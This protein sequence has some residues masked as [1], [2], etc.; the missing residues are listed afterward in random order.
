MAAVKRLRLRFKDSNDVI[1]SFTINPAHTPVDENNVLD[2][3]NRIINTNAFYTWTDGNIVA[4]EDASLI[5]T[6]ET[7]LDITPSTCPGCGE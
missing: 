1:V 6:E 5:S 3:M 7:E 2:Q 4:I